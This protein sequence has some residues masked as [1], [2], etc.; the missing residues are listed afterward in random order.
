MYARLLTQ[1]NRA[2]LRII[3][4]IRKR[5]C[6]KSAREGTFCAIIHKKCQFFYIPLIL[7]ARAAGRVRGIQYI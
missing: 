7:L 6:A 2:N 3:F 4:H 5:M 1:K